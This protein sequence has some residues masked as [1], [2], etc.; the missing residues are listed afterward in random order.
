[1]CGARW[2]QH[3]R[4]RVRRLSRGD[5]AWQETARCFLQAQSPKTL[6]CSTSTHGGR[7]EER[8]TTFGAEH[9]ATPAEHS[10]LCFRKAQ[11]PKAL[12]SPTLTH[13]EGRIKQTTIDGAQIV[14]R[15]QSTPFCVFKNVIFAFQLNSQ[16]ERLYQH[17]GLSEHQAIDTCLRWSQV[18]SLLL[19]GPHLQFCRTWGVSIPTG[20]LGFIEFCCQLALFRIVGDT[21]R[22]RCPYYIL[23]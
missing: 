16:E 13:G 23:R 4:R 1:M 22:K 18:S 19:P 2:Q 15:Q 6:C 9:H 3:L 11:S 20:S 12:C 17:N 7:G 8:Q 5:C 10:F 21:R 14:L